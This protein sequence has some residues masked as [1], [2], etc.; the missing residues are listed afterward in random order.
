MRLLFL[1]A[2]YAEKRTWS[3]IG[4]AASNQALA[5]AALGCDVH[6]VSPSVEDSTDECSNPRLHRLS[7]RSFPLRLSGSDVIH[8]HSLSLAALAR[9]SKRRYGIRL[10]YT[11][12]SL[13]SLELAGTP[14]CLRWSRLQEEVFALADKVFF[15]TGEDRAAACSVSPELAARSTVLPNGV[16]RP[17]ASC[18]TTLRKRTAMFVGRFTRHKGIDIF[19]GTIAG[20]LD[21]GCGW[22][23]VIAGGHGD[24][25]L[26]E[27]V[28][29]LS[30]R[31]AGRCRFTGWLDRSSLEK[32]YSQASLVM[33]PSRYEP[34]GM[35]ALEAMSRGVPVLASTAGGLRRIMGPTSGGYTIGRNQPES[36]IPACEA[37]MAAPAERE[38]LSL[39]GPQYVA[40]H[41]DA[42]N[43]AKRYLAEICP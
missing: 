32:L 17:F 40:Q 31:Y 1:T 30:K 35:V 27:Q 28:G 2:D 6:V 9:E 41:F 22:D 33:I 21:R 25:H 14:E 12:H 18:E 37:L 43:L 36:W 15:L 23:F 4:V 13:V 26:A 42:I 24:P 10:L 29:N 20:L 39:Q 3:G 7:R 8:L 34:F 16:N 5:L 11:A 19:A 38:F